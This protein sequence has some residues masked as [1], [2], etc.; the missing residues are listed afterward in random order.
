MKNGSWG[1]QYNVGFDC[2]VCGGGVH[3]SI[4]LADSCAEV[5]IRHDSDLA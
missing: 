5:C 2:Y 4:L 1:G 3:I